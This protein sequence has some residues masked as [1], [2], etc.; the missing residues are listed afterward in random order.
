MSNIKRVD[1]Q[2][3]CP[4]DFANANGGR[5]DHAA[6]DAAMVYLGGLNLPCNGLR[7]EFTR[8]SFYLPTPRTGGRYCHYGFTISGE[9]AFGYGYF[10]ELIKRFEAVGCRFK[11]FKVKDVQWDHTAWN[12]PKIK[13][14]ELFKNLERKA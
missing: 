12:N 11:Y 14:D 13:H 2:G 7:L 9:E 10:E 4:Y 8:S 3:Y 6:H 1:A 5:Y